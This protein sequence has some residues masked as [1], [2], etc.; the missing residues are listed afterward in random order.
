MTT[1]RSVEHRNILKLSFSLPVQNPNSMP[2][3]RD[4]SANK[5]Q[6]ILNW[7]DAKDP[8]TGLPPQGN[9]PGTPEPQQAADPGPCEL[10]ANQRDLG[11]KVD[12][13]R[14]VLKHNK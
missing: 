14:Q 7:L 3:T 8:V 2:V 5:R 6:T 13:L 12:F 10:P 1:I 4:L 11:S 9:V